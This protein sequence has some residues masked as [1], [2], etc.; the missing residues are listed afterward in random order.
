MKAGLQGEERRGLGEGGGVF[1]TP[2]RVRRPALSWPERMRFLGTSSVR[3][4]L[5]HVIINLALGDGNMRVS[6]G[7]PMFSFG[8]LGKGVAWG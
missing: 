4:E 1:H 6:L 8:S 3:N 5:E 2:D 7:F